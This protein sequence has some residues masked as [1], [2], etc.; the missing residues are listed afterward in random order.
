MNKFDNFFNTLLQKYIVKES[1]LNI[2]RDSLDPTV[3][4]F[5][6]DGRLPIFRDGIKKQIFKDID[7]IN[8][9]IPVI[10][11]F[12]IGSSLT[13]HYIENSDIDVNVQ[14][15]IDE[16]DEISSA[17]ILQ[18]IKRLN[19]KLA[20]GTTHPINYFVYAEEF[21]PTKAEAIYDI[22]NERWV[23]QPEEINPDV[24]SYLI[25]F[26]NTLQNMDIT[27]GEIRRSL[28]D[29]N[30]LKKLKKA[31][32]KE[33]KRLIER[34][35]EELEESITQ[36]ITVYKD[37]SVLRRLAFDRILTPQEIQLYGSKNLL[38]ENIIYK[39]LE[40]Y[41]YT[42]FI[43]SLKEIIGDEEGVKISDIKNIEKAG[44]K[45]WDH[46]NI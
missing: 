28:I 1:V 18:I 29:L 25:K 4:Q 2:S 42:D 17:Q 5:F 9:I 7:S 20:I 15:G 21:D 19:G 14:I 16:A 26:Q 33:L 36:I 23:R 40:K 6:D 44:K 45:L 30:E 34:K 41:Y 38:P 8:S 3:F 31:D 22:A 37:I 10:T 39:L 12:A 43:K 32:I 24:Q 13:K 27:T 35:L 11:F 46:E